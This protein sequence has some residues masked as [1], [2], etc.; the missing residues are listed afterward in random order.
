MKQRLRW[1]LGLGIVMLVLGGCITTVD[2]YQPPKQ[3]SPEV[4][5]KSYLDLGVAYMTRKRYDLA[6]SKLFRSV[7]VHPTA[8]AYNALAV[9]YEEQHKNALAEEMYKKLIADYPEYALGYINYNIFLCKYN[10]FSQMGALSA[11]AATRSKDIMILDQIA[12]GNCA[13]S[14]GDQNRAK[15]H[16]QKALTYDPHSSGALVPLA[17]MDLQRGFV[18]EAKKKI[19]LVHNYVGYSPRSV[20]LSVLIAREL[21]HHVEARKMLQVIKNRYSNT[22]EAAELLGN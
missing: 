20:Y 9:L 19:D 12:A 7:E 13:V 16:Y 1:G 8:E 17:E 21:G 15:Q 18:E 4:R 5:A 14:K 3:K 22:P 11:S 2:G 10:R 6:E